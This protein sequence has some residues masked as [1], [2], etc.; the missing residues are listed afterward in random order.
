MEMNANVYITKVK[1]GL[2]LVTVCKSSVCVCFHYY[3]CIKLEHPYT[4][5]SEQGCAEEFW[6]VITG[7]EDLRQSDCLV[8][9]PDRGIR[10]KTCHQGIC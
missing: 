4:W 5:S 2:G 6:R 3:L 9:I 1:K 10:Q 8:L 7:T